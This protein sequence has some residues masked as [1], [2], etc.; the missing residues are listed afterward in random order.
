MKTLFI[1][2][3]LL[4]GCGGSEEGDEK[5]VDLTC[6]QAMKQMIGRNCTY[7][8]GSHAMDKDELISFCRQTKRSASYVRLG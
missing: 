3:A 7:Y 5:S 4:L 1:L 2:C 8:E 6:E